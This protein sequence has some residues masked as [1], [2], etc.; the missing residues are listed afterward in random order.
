MTG[1]AP[2]ALWLCALSLCAA[3]PVSG[4]PAGTR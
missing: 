2:F 3:F 4:G 1:K